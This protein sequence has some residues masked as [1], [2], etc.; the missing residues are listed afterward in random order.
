MQTDEHW[1]EVAREICA[2]NLS[3][4]LLTLSEKLIRI[5]GDKR[6]E[7][8]PD[9]ESKTAAHSRVGFHPT[10]YAQGL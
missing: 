4:N 2:E 7:D 10:N 9:H 1:R 3:A 5:L 6:Q 8:N